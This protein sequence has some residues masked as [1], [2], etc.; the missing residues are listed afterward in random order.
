LIDS[1]DLAVYP[2]LLGRG[3]QFFRN[4]QDVRLRLV[5]TKTF[6][7]IVKLTYQPQY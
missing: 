1:I 6:S 7:A 2:R 4:G 3:K 5:A